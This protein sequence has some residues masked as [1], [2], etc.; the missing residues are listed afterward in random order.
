[1]YIKSNNKRDKNGISFLP[2][3]KDNNENS[4]IHNNSNNF[5]L[6]DSSLNN[7]RR[8][9]DILLRLPKIN[10]NV[11][12]GKEP[13]YF[14]VNEFK[15]SMKHNISNHS[16]DLNNNKTQYSKKNYNNCNNNNSNMKKR[17]N[18][19]KKNYISP[20]SKKT[21]ANIIQIS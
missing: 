5:N 9:L 3:I 2:E 1:M 12:F 13:S 20:Y 6:N 19:V 8:N 11:K 4:S 21:I 10:E 17:M 15:N 18:E 7:S 16:I 14:N